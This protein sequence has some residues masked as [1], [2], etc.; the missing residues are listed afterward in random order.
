MKKIAFCLGCAVLVL[1]S[2]KKYDYSEGEM[3]TVDPKFIQINNYDVPATSITLQNDYVDSLDTVNFSNGLTDTVPFVVSNPYNIPFS[4]N[5]D[6]A[7][8]PPL[9]F[10]MVY[11]NSWAELDKANL[12]NN[13]DTLFIVI[14]P[15]A[16]NVGENRTLNVLI[17]HQDYLIRTNHYT[18]YRQN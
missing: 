11:N 10:L 4:F 15:G 12:N 1:S 16:L 2:C 13:G 3:S 18:A 9:S 6:V 5:L 8:A 17:K 7:S 14:G